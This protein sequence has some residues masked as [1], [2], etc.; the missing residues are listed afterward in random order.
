MFELRKH[1]ITLG[2]LALMTI[3]CLEKE[4][5]KRP[6]IVLIT[7]D[8]LGWTD[9]G[10]FGSSYYETP[11]I[12][13]LSRGGVTFT[14]AYAAAA[15]C[16]PTRAAI[17]TG[18]H[19]A[20]IGIT[21]VIVPRFQGGI[22]VDG[23]NPT[24]YRTAKEGVK[25]PKNLLFLEKDEITIAE[26]LKPLGYSTAHIGKWHLGEDNWYP[27]NQGY[28]VNIGGCDFGQPPSYFDPYK[29]KKLNG[30]PTLKPRKEGEYLMDREA[31]EAVR[32]I[33]T[34]KDA[35]FFL[36]WSPYAV[37]TPIQAKDSLIRKY[38][39]KPVT[40]Q[41]KPNYA[42]MVQSLDEAIGQLVA[43]LDRNNLSEN[44]LII[45]TSDNGGLLGP[46]HNAPLRLGKGYEYEG[47]IRIPQIFYWPG[48]LEEGK[49][50]DEPVISMDIYPTIAAVSGA[51][52]HNKEIDGANLWPSV[53][54]N[55][56]MEKRSLMWHFPH[57]R[58]SKV[59]PYSIVRD[60]DWKFIKRYRQETEYELYN[61]SDDLSEAHDLATEMPEKVN[62]LERKLMDMLDHTNAKL[63]V[64]INID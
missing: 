30:I 14:N 13:K 43:C 61:L 12:D 17:Q 48:Q 24:G 56:P 18:R 19:P 63:P 8:D 41:T 45:F 40:N 10:C 49:V 21:N 42:A 4:A 38:E 57:F 29:N 47:G 23:K 22:V 7:V 3:S 59:K 33:E 5:D 58:L 46:T 64:Q 27:T 32:F 20:R 34:N 53:A 36:N 54:G 37:H 51:E 50:V 6:N 25:C 9:L 52:L 15:V 39:G 44:T 28:D 55:K 35:P 60:G 26:M 1:Y 2:I 31:D 16:S 11:N 62:E